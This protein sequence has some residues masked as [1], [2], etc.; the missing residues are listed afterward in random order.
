MINTFRRQEIF[1]AHYLNSKQ[2]MTTSCCR[3]KACEES[4]FP[5]ELD[6]NVGLCWNEDSCDTPIPIFASLEL[7]NAASTSLCVDATLNK[8]LG[9]PK[10]T[11][12]CLYSAV[13]D[14]YNEDDP[15]DYLPPVYVASA[16]PLMSSPVGITTRVK[17]VVYRENLADPPGPDDPWTLG[18]FQFYLQ[19]QGIENPF[20][21]FQTYTQMR[22][23]AGSTFQN[24]V[25]LP[26]ETECPAP[27][28]PVATTRLHTMDL[29]SHY[30]GMPT[31]VSGDTLVL[32]YEIA[33]PLSEVYYLYDDSGPTTNLRLLDVETRGTAS[34]SSCT[35]TPF[36]G[37]AVYA[38]NVHA[39]AYCGEGVDGTTDLAVGFTIVNSFNEP[40]AGNLQY[41]IELFVDNNAPLS[42]GPLDPMVLGENF[43]AYEFLGL[44]VTTDTECMIRLYSVVGNQLIFASQTPFKP[45]PLA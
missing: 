33:N 14:Y 1:H 41:G 37:E 35:T 24:I 25:G 39:I 31:L 8:P 10:K 7:A 11:T 42:S 15:P 9:L 2:T 23:I 4:G 21:S 26:A 32:F 43:Y 5:V 27:Y 20:L 17:A 38:V 30:A 16:A 19:S 22:N 36:S 44:D 13:P 29:Q 6:G 18:N 45:C 28:Q 40:I 34:A 3:V 12:R